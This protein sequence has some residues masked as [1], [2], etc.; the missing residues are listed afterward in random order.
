MD[1]DVYELICKAI[2]ELK[3]GNNGEALLILERTV[4][5]KFASKD[6]SRLHMQRRFR[7]QMVE[8]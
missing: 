2:T 7:L 6:A 8:R 3:A 4:D 1:P 5:P